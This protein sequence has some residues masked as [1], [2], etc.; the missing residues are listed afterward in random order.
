MVKVTS[1]II[2]TESTLRFSFGVR[3]LT[4]MKEGT[5]VDKRVLLGLI[6]IFSHAFS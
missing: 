3:A 2:V 6:L 1:L 5:G 4:E